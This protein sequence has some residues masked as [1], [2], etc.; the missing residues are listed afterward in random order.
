VLRDEPPAAPGPRAAGGDGPRER[1][2][3]VRRTRRPLAPMASSLDRAVWM[4]VQRSELWERLGHDAHDLLSDQPAPYGD[5]FAWLD[6]TVHDHG[7]LAGPALLDEMCAPAAPETFP[8]LAARMR[9]FHDMPVGD[10][11]SAEIGVILDRLRLQVV[12]S[13]LELL[14]E[15][16]GLSDAARLRQRELYQQQAELKKRLATPPGMQV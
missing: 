6:R 4:L 12:A 10:D 2:R 11:A 8:A 16:E 3:D 7:T 13:E 1:P 5:F 9:Q 14:I 15:T